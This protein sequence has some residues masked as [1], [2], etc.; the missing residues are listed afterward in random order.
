MKL[1]K[2]KTENQLNKILRQCRQTK[3]ATMFLVTSPWD[4]QGDKIFKEMDEA[5]EESLID[6]YEIDYFELPHAY[7][8]FKAPTPSL[9]LVEGKKTQVFDN[10][11][12]IRAEL[13]LDT[14][15]VPQTP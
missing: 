7:C 15:A 12:S 2:L 9:V 1:K 3:E 5:F 8:I 11:M 13:G 6:F 10:P 4:T 14:L